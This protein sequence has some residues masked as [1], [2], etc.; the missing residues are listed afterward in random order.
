MQLILHHEHEVA[1]TAVRPLKLPSLQIMHHTRPVTLVLSLTA[2]SSPASPGSH[3]STGKRSN[4]IVSTARSSSSHQSIHLTIPDPGRRNK[5]KATTEWKRCDVRP[6]RTQPP[7]D[8]NSIWWQGSG[9]VWALR[10]RSQ[11]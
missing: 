7:R 4:S 11:C 1:H 6:M 8:K 9:L 5:W 3:H 2:R 10:S